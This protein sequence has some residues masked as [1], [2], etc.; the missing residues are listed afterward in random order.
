MSDETTNG[1]ENSRLAPVDREV[2][3]YERARNDLLAYGRHMETCALFANAKDRGW[4]YAKLIGC[5]C[6]FD[7]AIKAAF[8]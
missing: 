8:A 7:K 6:G 2:G 5:S 4:R 3:P 1:S